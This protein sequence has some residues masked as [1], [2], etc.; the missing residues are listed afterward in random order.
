[1]ISRCTDPDCKDYTNYGGRG[2]TVCSVWQNDFEVFR[3]WALAN[4]CNNDRSL[5]RIDNDGDYSPENCRWATITEQNRNTRRVLRLT[6]FDETK[7][8]SEW[9]EDPRCQVSYFTL[10]QRIVYLG[11]EP[12]AALLCSKH[13][14]FRS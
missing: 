10:R 12:E 14:D 11:W 8:L 7:T 13:Q 4:G 3:T 1:M 6:V 2:I 5:D 9:A